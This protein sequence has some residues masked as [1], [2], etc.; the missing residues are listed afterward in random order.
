MTCLD[1]YK[2][3]EDPFA[4]VYDRS[5]YFPTA[6]CTQVHKSLTEAISQRR[7]VMLLTGRIGVGKTFALNQLCSGLP[8]EW[9]A[10]HILN[11]PQSGDDLLRQLASCA[12]LPHGPA[13]LPDLRTRIAKQFARMN[14]R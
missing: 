2:L 1:F 12:G 6:A 5:R 10:L 8:P 3:R 11:P 4:D 7:G 13:E 9:L 14:R